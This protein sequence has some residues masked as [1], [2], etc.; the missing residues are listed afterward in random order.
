[1]EP[2]KLF[3]TVAKEAEIST[4]QAE[5]AVNTFFFNLAAMNEDQVDSFFSKHLE[6]EDEG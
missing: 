6:E 2:Q 4:K 5:I 1:M 3:E